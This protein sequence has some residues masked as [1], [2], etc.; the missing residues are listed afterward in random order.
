MYFNNSKNLMKNCFTQDFII[1]I[2]K[3]LNQNN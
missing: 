2:K 3:K 1:N